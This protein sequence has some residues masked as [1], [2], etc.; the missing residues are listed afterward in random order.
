MKK[1][2]ITFSGVAYDETTPL[3]V[4]RGPK[5]GADEVWVYDDRWLIGTQFYKTNYWIFN[6]RFPWNGELIHHGFGWCCWKAHVILDAF[7]RL[8]P[9]DIVFYVDADTYP[10]ADL[11]PIFEMCARDA[12]VLFEA[13]GCT[14]E[15]YTR[16]D[17]FD[18][19]SLPYEQ[20]CQVMACGRFSAWKKVRFPIGLL[21]AWDILSRNIKALGWQGSEKPGYDDPNFMR[22]STE[23]SVLSLLAIDCDIPRHREACQ[24]GWPPQPG[25]GQPEDTYPQLFHQQWCD[26]DRSNLS[27]SRFFHV[28]GET[29]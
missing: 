10:I 9:G 15:V 29:R 12:V 23:Q 19:M 1:I 7:S 22:H 2:L 11:S 4:E 25:C 8:Q 17:L 27:G 20:R 13:Q 21:L 14:N 28:P 26:G 3:I 16:R 5:L 18:L 6:S 24:F